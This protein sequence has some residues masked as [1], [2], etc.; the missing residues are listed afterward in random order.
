MTAGPARRHF[1]I[2]G[3]VQGV[4]FRW[5]LREQARAL[6]LAGWVKN[7]DD[8][9]VEAAAEGPPG[10]LDRLAAWC[11]KGPPAARVAEVVAEDEP[12]EGEQGFRITG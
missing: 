11:A 5:Y 7:L 2:R 12:A 3:V 6:G 10:S 9:R 1:W 8:G 4:S